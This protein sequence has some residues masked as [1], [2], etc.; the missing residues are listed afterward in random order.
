MQ[1]DARRR[2]PRLRAGRRRRRLRVAV[3]GGS[4]HLADRLGNDE[5]AVGD[6]R[7]TARCGSCAPG[8]CTA[9]RPCR[10][11]AR[12]RR[13]DRA[14]AAARSRA[15][16]AR[17]R[18]AARYDR[19]PGPTGESARARRTAERGEAPVT[20]SAE[21][22]DLGRTSG[23]TE[24]DLVFGF[25]HMAGMPTGQVGLEGEGSEVILWKTAG[26]QS[27]RYPAVFHRSTSDPLTS[28]LPEGRRP[29]SPACRC[30]APLRQDRSTRCA[31]SP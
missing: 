31:T 19:R 12:S 5:D 23:V 2:R 4:G 29:T 10:P 16:R 6:R 27:T 1:R 17:R 21:S 20:A 24:I 3:R 11:E 7:V 22:L 13:S 15:A 30:G 9:R 18:A 14:P 28:T 26:S 25:E 8:R